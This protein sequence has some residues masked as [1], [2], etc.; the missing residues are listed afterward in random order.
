MKFLGFPKNSCF[1]CARQ[2]VAKDILGWFVNKCFPFVSTLHLV[3][4]LDWTFFFWGGGEAM[5]SCWWDSKEK[6]KVYQKKPWCHKDK[7]STKE[8]KAD[9][10]AHGSHMFNH[11]CVI[12]VVSKHSTYIMYLLSQHSSPPVLVSTPLPY[13]LTSFNLLWK[14]QGTFILLLRQFNK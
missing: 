14:Y 6:K 2:F 13:I 4:I 3:I 1:I 5:K 9:P 11:R 10:V 8:D 7:L 12:I